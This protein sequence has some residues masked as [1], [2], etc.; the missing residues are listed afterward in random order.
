MKNEY[1]ILFKELKYLYNLIRLPK[2]SLKKDIIEKGW[3][4]YY[5]ISDK[6]IRLTL[7]KQV[8][9]KIGW[10]PIISI[11]EGHRDLE[12]HFY[13]P[14]K[15]KNKVLIGG[16]N[17]ASLKDTNRRISIKY[18][19]SEC[20]KEMGNKIKIFSNADIPLIKKIFV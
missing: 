1:P 12:I 6:D 9:A 11:D 10:V 3:R 14:L 15:R 18:F 20:Q 5:K 7:M 19:C 4:L 13:K 2:E 8:T 17:K 16:G